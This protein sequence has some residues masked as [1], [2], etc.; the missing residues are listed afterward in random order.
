MNTITLKFL[1][2][3]FLFFARDACKD[4]GPAGIGTSDSFG[5][6]H[7]TSEPQNRKAAWERKGREK[8]KADASEGG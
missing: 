5:P 1:F 2:S 4:P 6:E 7:L 8:V 3:F